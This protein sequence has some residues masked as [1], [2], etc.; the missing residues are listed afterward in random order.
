MV[1]VVGTGF[2]L[3]GTPFCVSGFNAY[4]LSYCSDR[5]QRLVLQHAADR[6]ANTVRAWAFHNHEDAEAWLLRLDAL[7]A[8]AEE[9][10]VFLILPLTNGW[11]DFGGMPAYAPAGDFF[12]SESAMRAYE[13]W[14]ERVLTRRNSVS[15]RLYVDEPAVLGWELANEPR[16][17][18]SDNKTAV[19]DWVER[20]SCAIKR[21]DNRH[22]LAVGDEGFFARPRRWW[23]RLGRR[24]HLYDGRYSVDAR[25]FLALDSIDFGTYH[26][27]PDNWGV[28]AAFGTQWIREH[29]ALGN[30]AG[31][32]VV[33]EEFGL[34]ESCDR[35]FDYY[36]EWRRLASEAGAGAL[37]WMIGC[38]EPESAGFCD[39]YTLREFPAGTK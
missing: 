21:L 16:A 30:E 17:G 38:D 22:L 32:P 10:G 23:K 18:A 31:K 35:R 7:L 29:A 15:G 20:A 28:S 2:V 33:L 19:L 1:G 4:Y 27:Y 39:R 14:V 13:V 25:A 34:P 37:L 11:A 9:A 3:D 6:G 5:T 36:A 12:R 8:H 26:F 24:A